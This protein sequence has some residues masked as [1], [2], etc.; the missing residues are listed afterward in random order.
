MQ[1]NTT[2]KTYFELSKSVVLD[3][4]NLVKPLADITSYSSKTNPLITPILE[5]HTSSVFSIHFLAELQHIKDMSRV[6][7]LAQA[8]DEKEILFL[9]KKG[10]RSFC[11]DNK[12]DLDIFL[13]VLKQNP[14]VHV[15]LFLRLRLKE[16]TIRTEKY[17]VFGMKSKELNTTSQEIHESKLRSQITTLGVH[18]HRKTQNMA[19]WNYSEEL[20]DEL[21]K[22]TL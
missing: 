11:V 6:F 5:K 4:Y 16:N 1:K 18:M 12:T 21:D 10:V 22:K 8:W 15:S 20:S 9:F 7:Y 2:P 19:E 14:L 3:Q 17:F 13:S